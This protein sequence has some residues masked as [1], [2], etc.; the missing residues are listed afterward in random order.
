MKSKTLLLFLLFLFFRLIPCVASLTS[1]NNS[2]TDDQ[3]IVK[4]WW[5]EWDEFN[6]EYR[7]GDL[8][9]Y[10]KTNDYRGWYMDL[11]ITSKDSENFIITNECCGKDRN[12]RSNNF[13]TF[14]N[15]YT[16]YY[17]KNFDFSNVIET[18]KGRETLNMT[19]LTTVKGVTH[20]YFTTGEMLDGSTFNFGG[21]SVIPAG[22]ALQFDVYA[23]KMYIH[24]IE[25]YYEIIQLGL[26][27]TPIPL[28]IVYGNSTVRP[29]LYNDFEGVLYFFAFGDE[30]PETGDVIS[31]I[32]NPKRLYS[33][34]KICNIERRARV[35]IAQSGQNLIEDCT[36]TYSN[37]EYLNSY[38]DCYELSKYRIF[39]I[40]ASQDSLPDQQDWN[41]FVINEDVS[42]T[43]PKTNHL[44]FYGDQTLPQHSFYFSGAI[45]FQK[46][47]IQKSTAYYDLGTF[48]LSAVTISSDVDNDAVLF[49]GIARDSDHIASLGI[50]EEKCGDKTHRFVQ[51][52]SNIGCNCT[53]YSDG[54]F[55]QFDCD[56]ATKRPQDN[57]LNLNLTYS[58]DGGN[59]RRYWGSIFSVLSSSSSNPEEELAISGSEIF[60][61]NLCD[62]NGTHNLRIKGSLM[63]S[64][65][66]IGGET[67]IVVD[68]GATLSFNKLTIIGEIPDNLNKKALIEVKGTLGITS[69]I[70]VDFDAVT[71]NNCFE[72]ATSDYQF[73]ISLNSLKTL[74]RG[75]FVYNKLLR[76][77][78]LDTINTNVDCEIKDNQYGK[79]EFQQCPCSSSDKNTFNCNVFTNNNQIDFSKNQQLTGAT[80]VVKKDITILNIKS[81]E[82]LSTSG[83]ITLEIQSASSATIENMVFNDVSPLIV[84]KCDLEVY[85][86]VGFKYKPSQKLTFSSESTIIADLYEEP[87][88]SLVLSASVKSLSLKALSQS[89]N[90][91][92]P[93]F[94]MKS[95][96]DVLTVMLLPTTSNVD[97]IILKRLS[98]EIEI[99]PSKK[100]E[101]LFECSGQALIVYNNPS[102]P[103]SCATLGLLYRSCFA[104]G[105]GCYNN[106]EAL[107]D[108]SCPCLQT[109]SQCV[110][111][112]D[113]NQFDPTNDLTYLVTQDTSFVSTTY[114]RNFKI[115]SSTNQN[116]I[117]INGWNM[118]VRVLGLEGLKIT[119]ANGKYDTLSVQ[120]RFGFV[121]PSNTF[122]NKLKSASNHT[123]S[124]F[125]SEDYVTFTISSKEYCTD[126]LIGGSIQ[127]IRCGNTSPNSNG[128]CNQRG[129]KDNC[130]KYDTDGY[131]S[132]CDEGFYLKGDKFTNILCATCASVD[133]NNCLKCTS[134]GKCLL[135]KDGYRL[136][137]NK[138]EAVVN[139]AGY[140]LGA[141][142]MCSEGTYLSAG[143]CGENCNTDCSVC[144]SST[145]CQVCDAESK[146][147]IKSDLT[148]CKTDSNAITV[149]YNNVLSCI[150]GFVV[151]NGTCQ[152]CTPNC[153]MC[154][155]DQC[156]KCAGGFSLVSGVCQTV[157][158][159]LL[160]SESKCKRCDINYY[161]TSS[162]S[163]GLCSNINCIHCRDNTSNSCEL[164]S[165]TTS[166]LNGDCFTI[167]EDVFPHCSFFKNGEC[168][169]CDV[170]YVLIKDECKPCTYP[171]LS[172]YG[173]QTNCL[174]CDSTHFL[175]NTSS[176]TNICYDL[177]ILK[178]T[179][180]VP[181]GQMGCAVCKDSYYVE[182]NVC[183]DCTANCI[184]CHFNTS[185]EKCDENYFL[186]QNDCK[187]YEELTNCELKTN[188]GCAKCT[189]GYFVQ[190]QF[191]TPCHLKTDNCATCGSG[192]CDS[193]ETDYILTLKHCVYLKDVSQCLEVTSSKCTRCSFW[194]SVSDTGLYCEKAVVWWVILLI[195]LFC[196]LFI[197][198]FVILVM[199]LTLFVMRKTMKNKR[200][201]NVNYFYMRDTAIRFESIG[202]SFLVVD[203]KV[204]QFALTNDNEVAIPVGKVA[205]EKICLGNTGKEKLK[206]QFTTKEDDIAKFIL[207]IY[208]EMA[209]LKSGEACE[210]QVKLTPQCTCKINE[211][212]Q[213]VSVDLR[214]GV[215]NTDE[216]V[217]ETETQMSTRLDYDE[218][219]LDKQ[220]GEGSFGTV[221]K[222]MFRNNPVAIKI[223]K[224]PDDTDAMEEFEKE[225]A[226]LD[227]FRSDFVVHF[228]G[229]VF[230]PTKTCMV[231]E[232]AKY[233]SL[234]AMFTKK[235]KLDYYLRVKLMIDSAKGIQYL[236][237]NG[238][239][240][241]DIKSDNILVFSV[242]KGILVNGKLTDFGSSRNIN[243]MRSNMTF[244]KGIG[245]PMY[246]SPEILDQ[247]KYSEKADI[248]S[249]S[250]V[251]F[252]IFHW[253]N[254]YSKDKFPFPWNIA[255]F[256][257][258]NKRLSKPSDMPDWLFDLIAASWD[259]NP[260]QRPH[261]N[262]IV[263]T[264]QDNLPDW[265]KNK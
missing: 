109:E 179:C 70:S 225:V 46:I 3:S 162:G 128:L 134:R 56:D 196:V 100:S 217:I 206:V 127:C 15:T 17:Y 112:L 164:C 12:N 124:T 165:D 44:N 38:V 245:T 202:R 229:A 222:G 121:I 26:R 2:K 135:C 146:Y 201:D 136:T 98:R 9:T 20:Y 83:D 59:Q 237:T 264:L 232:F 260:S 122:T 143:E 87:T 142:R 94:S 22:S 27:I 224:I 149:G 219:I 263:N 234:M 155:R 68:E 66:I 58:Y 252:E 1:L 119:V 54:S 194:Y 203:K 190:N 10:D 215:N 214:K 79:F 254:P 57:L 40:S 111:Q 101:Y 7:N 246:M 140:V 125:K 198:L 145:S 132:E 181:I 81:I 255:E 253:G 178:E 133:A 244:T 103:S 39:N 99:T 158:K 236:H 180:K 247:S 230:I 115:V 72:F 47:I 126:V 107:R 148:T 93:L 259:Q 156:I 78:K 60:V 166:L 67:H 228:Y 193:C 185:C 5:G 85:D 51:Q 139:C 257:S 189:D 170:G 113:G 29:V 154:V 188:I 160:V 88:S 74:T 116:V 223:M 209:V 45:N 41:S 231:T 102:S 157:S 32:N 141:C 261:I 258:Q 77:C 71:S 197:A 167:S 43:L 34:Y 199:F 153:E 213:I 62:F 220:I 227:K 65:L 226:M 92:T 130:N 172:C 195:V 91:T 104:C 144:S 23:K 35:V 55:I 192:S 120:G 169:S 11:T 114:L 28:I 86:T 106:E 6:I 8:W 13:F 73:D 205:E 18:D 16:P 256:I 50:S 90:K 238:I 251:M 96:S 129:L 49:R 211:K 61:T 168:Q 186:Y 216:I 163:C 191:C 123:K 210:F 33:T 240:H 152:S 218:L 75:I 14:H 37:F 69:A 89:Q 84:S 248:F 241:R 76:I 177:S 250:I 147:F 208:P 235:K 95:T 200:P 233:G 108:Y 242:D 21:R 184:Q 110:I 137:N 36:C 24:V 171:C 150:N 174:S 175:Q 118:F 4:Q 173:T 159:C 97:R 30:L 52:T 243:M 138:C 82:R 117:T 221:Y 19:F 161:V 105:S 183:K 48:T 31:S 176:V 207:E 53:Q 262:S 187:S 42:L 80:L 63:C 212:L 64:E 204:L 25:G 249:F 131:C 182:N 265:T 151:T 239:M